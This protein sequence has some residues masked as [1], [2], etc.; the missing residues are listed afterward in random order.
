MNVTAVSIGSELLNGDTLNTNLLHLGARL[1]DAGVPLRRELCVPDEEEAIRKALRDALADS[2]VVV[3]IG[4][5][6][7]TCDDLT[8]PVV[9]AEL[10]LP[11]REDPRVAAGIRDFL[12]RRGVS[13]PEEALRI[14]SQVPE[15]AEVLPNPNG[16]A[17]GLWCRHPRPAAVVLLPGP[18]SEFIPM[19]EASV[20]P[21]LLSFLPPGVQAPRVVR[22]AGLPESLVEQRTEKALLGLPAL[23]TAYCARPGCV[24]VRVTDPLHRAEILAAAEERLRAAFGSLALPPGCLGPAHHIGVLLQERGWRLAV[25]ESCTGGLV[26]AA[27]TDVPGASAWFL[28][29]LVTYANAWKESLLGV[30]DATLRRHGAVSEPAV[31]HMLAGLQERFGVETAVAVSGIAGPTGGSPQKPVGTVFLGAAVPGHAEVTRHSFPGNRAAVRER[32]AAA[33]LVML[34]QALLDHVSP[35]APKP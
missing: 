4:G 8:R 1:A 18:P 28:G 33:A 6:G 26:A 3:T 14:Q 23:S 21:R 29:G 35:G 9:A 19:V 12:A 27:V 25:A 13:L 10:G 7:P 15:S 22:V 5:L 2:D 32:A 24:T 17:P 30:P 20:L 34:R 16:T 31:R 11:L